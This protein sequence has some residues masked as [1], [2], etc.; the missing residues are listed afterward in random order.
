MHEEAYNNNIAKIKHATKKLN[1]VRDKIQRYDA[2]IKMSRAEAEMAE[3]ARTFDFDVTTDFGQ[4]EQVIQ[5][6]ISLNR[7]KARVAADLSE[8]GLADIRAEE[9]MEQNMADEAL[10]QFELDMGL[11]TPETAG[12][13]GTTKELGPAQSDRETEIE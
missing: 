12:I 10:R 5:D 1:A 4:L 3:L 11:I 7:G 9:A 2:E 13:E 8:D 6:K